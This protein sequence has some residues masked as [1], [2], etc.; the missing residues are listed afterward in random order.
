MSTAQTKTAETKQKS[1]IPHI[2]YRD[3]YDD[4]M[5]HE[6]AIVK[7]RDNGGY[8]YIIIAQLDDLDKGR[9]KKILMSQYANQTEL[10]N[11]MANEQLSNGMNALDYFHQMVKKKNVQGNVHKSNNGLGIEYAAPVSNKLIGSLYCNPAEINTIS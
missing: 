1:N 2:D 11:L 3:I 4:G 8:D 5:R 6:V 9:L 7:T 10:W